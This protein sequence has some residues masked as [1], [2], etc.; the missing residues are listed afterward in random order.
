MGLQI[1]IT[2]FKQDKER[3]S[4][5]GKNDKKIRRIMNKQYRALSVKKSEVAQDVIR[6]LM[7]APFK[8][9]FK[10]C[11]RILFGGRKGVNGV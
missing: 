11:M 6:E 7:C 9:R 5:S 2:T 10:F 1:F 8:Y 4:M 3:L